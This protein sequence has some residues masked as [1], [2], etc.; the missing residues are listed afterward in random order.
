MS[1]QYTDR[2][3]MSARESFEAQIGGGIECLCAQLEHF[4][5][6]RTLE[7]LAQSASQRDADAAE[8]ARR[9]LR[10]RVLRRAAAL[11]PE[12]EAQS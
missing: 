11:L 4:I 10:D 3:P 1:D 7:L 9:I 2:R 6:L 8:A 5:D 12:R